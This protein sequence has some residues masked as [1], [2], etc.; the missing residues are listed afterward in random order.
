[1]NDIQHWR[2]MIQPRTRTPAVEPDDSD[3]A[4]S[5]VT[6]K[7]G[8]KPKISSMFTHHGVAAKPSMHSLTEDPFAPRLPS[9]PDEQPYSLHPD[10]EGLIDS[11]M[12]RLM[13]DPYGSLDSRFNSMLM[14]IFESYRS[15]M[16]EKQQLQEQA[17]EAAHG[18]KALL[19]RLQQ[20]QKQ[21]SQE[22]QDYKAE[23]KRL[24]LLLAKGKRGLAEV[25]T[26]RQDSQYRQ[27][28]SYRRSEMLDDGLRTIFEV[29]ERTQQ[30]NEKTWG[31]QRGKLR[32]AWRSG[33]VC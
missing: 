16:D 18:R 8:L 1:M 33:C 32:R 9:W 14:H 19:S 17:N 3:G 13:S 23:I 22:R 6:P 31:N 4:A 30:S 2:R 25:T 24:E 21:W 28:E 15:V 27:R 11:V 7:R 29:L 20:A 12:C 5:P 26:A 10:A